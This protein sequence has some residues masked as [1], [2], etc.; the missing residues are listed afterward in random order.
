MWLVVRQAS[1]F[2]RTCQEE[3]LIP[4]VRGTGGG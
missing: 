1:G 4:E 3:L 2:I